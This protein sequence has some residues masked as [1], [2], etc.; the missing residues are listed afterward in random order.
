[1]TKKK[2]PNLLKN[3]NH[4]P[5]KITSSLKTKKQNNYYTH[6]P[7][8]QTKKKKRKKKATSREREKKKNKKKGR[9]NVPKKTQK[10]KRKEETVFSPFEG[11]NFLVGSRIKYP[12]PTIYFSF[13]APH[14]IHSKKVFLPIFFSKIFCLPYFTFKQTHP[15]G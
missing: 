5:K 7:G 3:K 4:V 6:N 11:E 12:G 15:K 14:Q 10:I 1:M 13:S 9:G 8:N 2:S